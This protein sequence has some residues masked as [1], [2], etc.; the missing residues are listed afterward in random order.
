[1]STR[2]AAPTGRDTAHSGALAGSIGFDWVMS[3]LCGVFLGGLFLDGWAHT[4]GRVDNT[5]FTP[6]HA[7]LYSGYLLVA[8]FLIATT[9]WNRRRGYSWLRALPP[10]Y[11]WSLVGVLLWVPGGL[12]DLLWH[13]L[14]GFEASVDALLSPPHLV[15]ALGYGLMA[16]GPLRAAWR[17]PDRWSG[18]WRRVL[19]ALLSLT[20]LLS[21]IT[22]FTQIA[23][24]MANLWGHGAGPA[25]RGLAS[26]AAELGVTGLLLEAM[27]LT[28]TI[29]SLVRRFVLPFGALTVMIGINGALMGVLYEH[30]EYPVAQVLAMV[31]GGLIAD[32]LLRLLKPG[33]GMV[34][35]RIFAFAVPTVLYL[36]YF[37]V[38]RFVEGL[39]WTIHLSA[40]TIVLAG[41]LGWLLSYVAAPPEEPNGTAPA[42]RG[43]H[44]G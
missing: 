14:F 35:L 34:R 21:L 24:P 43:S 10:G 27:I 19:P 20:F 8:L 42:T 33:G 40:G 25:S 37:I 3:V 1:M 18:R 36:L 11:D 39:W 9:G 7:V 41:I 12:A 13:E 4:H 2:T 30:G 31:A 16:S 26:V 29:L 38:L 22:F 32:L 5:F 15:L 17:R 28:G 23:H 6:W 44:A